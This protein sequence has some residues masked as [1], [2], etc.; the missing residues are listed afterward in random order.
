MNLE[1]KQCDTDDTLYDHLNTQKQNLY[2]ISLLIGVDHYMDL[3]DEKSRILDMEQS[4]IA[5]L[6]PLST[7]SPYTQKY[8]PVSTLFCLKHLE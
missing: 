5:I 2:S 3:F 7:F 1:Q 8:N 6:S 4:F